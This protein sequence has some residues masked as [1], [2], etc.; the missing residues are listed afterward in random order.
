MSF[1][2]PLKLT[3]AAQGQYVNGIWQAAPDL[4]ITIEASVQPLS[5]ADIQKMPIGDQYTQRVKV[6]TDTPIRGM[7]TKEYRP[8]FEW[9]GRRWQVES[10]EDHQMDVI[11]HYKLIARR[12]EQ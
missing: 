7:T 1:R 8:T 6:Y 2:K 12:L 5:V 9:Q 10:I 3:V 4:P 11:P